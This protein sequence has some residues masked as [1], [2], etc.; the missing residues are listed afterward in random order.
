MSTTF[1][2]AYTRMLERGAMKFDSIKVG[3]QDLFNVMFSRC[4]INRFK[5]HA[6]LAVEP[7]ISDAMPQVSRTLKQSFEWI[8]ENGGTFMDPTG[9]EIKIWFNVLRYAALALKR[10]DVDC[11]VLHESAERAAKAL[12]LGTIHDSE[13]FLHSLSRE[14]SGFLER[15]RDLDQFAS[16]RID[17]DTRLLLD[18]EELAHRLCSEGR[19]D[20]E[21]EYTAMI[22]D[23]RF[24]NSSLFFFFTRPRDRVSQPNECRLDPSV[25]GTDAWTRVLALRDVGSKVES[26]NGVRSPDPRYL[27]EFRLAM[28]VTD[29]GNKV[30]LPDGW[31]DLVHNHVLPRQRLQRT[32][33]EARVNVVE[34]G[35]AIWK[36][37]IKQPTVPLPRIMAEAFAAILAEN[38]QQGSDA[39]ARAVEGYERVDRGGLQQFNQLFAPQQPNP[40]PQQARVRVK[41]TVAVMEPEKFVFE[42][43]EGGVILILAA[44]GLLFLLVSNA[45]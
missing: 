43:N 41:E 44:A 15:C 40:S 12:R 29:F 2:V 4:I 23:E 13:E 36:N 20:Q 32:H 22:A 21:Q 5:L 28:F 27:T 34:Y 26:R 19:N 11:T 24:Q 7:K 35:A 33:N 3:S 6:T 31:I 37:F 42:P 10:L 14:N 9:E 30:G 25:F 38:T 18:V 17:L 45:N 39:V 1:R 16:L 8:E